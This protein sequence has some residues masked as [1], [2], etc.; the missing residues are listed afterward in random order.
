LYFFLVVFIP[1]FQLKDKSERQILRGFQLIL[2]V[3]GHYV[4]FGWTVD[5]MSPD[6]S[7]GRVA[8]NGQALASR[9]RVE[10]GCCKKKFR[11]FIGTICSYVGD[12][13]CNQ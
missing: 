1:D 4:F 8:D 5:A 7:S 9:L 10:Q 13:F 12:F 11:F 3:F 6:S 2:A